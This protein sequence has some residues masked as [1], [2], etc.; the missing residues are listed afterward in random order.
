VGVLYDYF[1]APDR[2]TAETAL[3]RRAGPLIEDE[4]SGEPPFD[5]VACKGID[6]VLVLGKLVSYGIGEPWNLHLFQVKLIGALSDEGPWLE[7]LG[8]RV[9]DGLADIP[10]ADLFEVCTRWSRIEEFEMYSNVNPASL[11]ARATEFVALARRARV[12][13]HRLYCWSCL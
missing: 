1:R 4:D 10:D 12:D 5:G 2:A 11:L 6:P 13:G 3:L 7:E 8:S 9:R